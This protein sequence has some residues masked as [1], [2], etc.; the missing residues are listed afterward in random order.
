M[1]GTLGNKECSEHDA[2]RYPSTLIIR[3]RLSSTR[4]LSF[5]TVHWLR[6]TGIVP[7]PLTTACVV[8]QNGDIPGSR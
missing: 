6:G 5:L 2:P 3:I 4:L 7:T 8:S 1:E